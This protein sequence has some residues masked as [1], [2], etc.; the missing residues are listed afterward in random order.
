MEASAKQ[1]RQL[2]SQKKCQHFSVN[3]KTMANN[4]TGLIL[5]HIK[6]GLDSPRVLLRIR[7]DDGSIGIIKPHALNRR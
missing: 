6:C 3:T 7:W 4:R 1:H 2:M 5:E